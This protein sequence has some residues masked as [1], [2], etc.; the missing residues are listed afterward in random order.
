MRYIADILTLFRL[1]AGLVIV[2]L[3][4]ANNLPAAT[5][6]FAAGILS[7]AVDGMIARRWPY[8]EQQEK[9]LLWRRD[10]SIWDNLAD[11]TLVGCTFVAFGIT[12]LS[13]LVLAFLIAT[14]IVSTIFFVWAISAQKRKNLKRAKALDITYRWVFG[15]ELVGLLVWMTVLASDAWMWWLLV[16]AAAGVALLYLKWDHATF[17]DDPTYH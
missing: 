8:S 13:W 7:D 3:I 10:A 6:L 9:R 1:I 12:E 4:A 5:I 15:A 14:V 17:K 2:Y 16:Y 11:A